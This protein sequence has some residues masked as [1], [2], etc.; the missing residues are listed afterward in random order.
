MY[1]RYYGEIGRNDETVSIL[2]T[3][4]KK[5]FEILNINFIFKSNESF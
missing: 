1:F 4:Y 2:S 3:D 5:C